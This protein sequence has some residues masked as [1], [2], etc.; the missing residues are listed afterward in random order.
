MSR[1]LI[2]AFLMALILHSLL[3]LVELN[4][5]KRSVSVNV[6][7]ETL[8]IDIAKP[9]LSG[10][11]PLI[12]SPVVFYKEPV[13]EK[14]ITKKLKPELEVKTKIKEKKVIQIEKPILK[15]ETTK[16]D[17]TPVN[18][19]AIKK[20]DTFLVEDN[21]F[22]PDMVDI[23]MALPKSRNTPRAAKDKEL[24]DLSPDVPVTYAMPV[25][26]R[27]ISPEYPLLAKKRGY[28]GRV[29]LEVL[30]KK[31]GKAGSIRLGK[32]SG[33][34]ILDRA[35]IKGVKNWIFHPAKRGDELVEMWVEIPIRFQLK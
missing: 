26:R 1:S 2:L 10:K 14:K 11:P 22:V 29:L 28:Q 21:S 27:N 12:K 9:R 16:K 31:D 25:Y 18:L 7:P 34:E 33:Y 30:V 6:L 5:F 17:E 23:P 35:A 3:V 24:P 13:L 4:A 20:E 19:A 8:T 32:S 15:K